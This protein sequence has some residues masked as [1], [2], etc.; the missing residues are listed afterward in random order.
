MHQDLISKKELL[1]LV[2]ITYGQLYR[3]K[4][5]KLIPEEWFIRKSTYTGQET[6][7]PKEQIL[8]RIEKIQMMK[9]DASLDDLAE[10]FSPNLTKKT[11]TRDNLLRR[12][13]VTES[14]MDFFT[15]QTGDT[16]TLSFENTLIVYVLDELLKTGEINLDEGKSVLQVL[17]EHYA[18]FNQKRSQLI[19]IRKLGMST[20]FLCSSPSD[21]YFEKDVRVVAHM[22]LAK[23]IEELKIKLM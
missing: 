23:A 22:D 9:G 8:S 4:R 2:E 20:C 16:L 13:I 1:D 12:N 15:E 6:F 3:W 7:F 19:F 11:F 21:I 17:A 5:K 10:M 14:V 18:S